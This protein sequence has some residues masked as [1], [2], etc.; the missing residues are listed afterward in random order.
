MVRRG[1]SL[2]PSFSGHGLLLLNSFRHRQLS[3]EFGAYLLVVSLPASL[4]L[5]IPRYQGLALS[6]G[7]YLYCGSAYGPGGIAARVAR[8]A[9]RE[10]ARR[11][12]IDHL[13][14]AGEVVLALA[15]PLASECALVTRLCSAGACFP[16]PGF[17]SSD[18][19]RC[20]AHLLRG[21]RSIVSTLVT[22]GTRIVLS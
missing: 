7:R 16:L 12:H 21:T 22:S 20:P 10:K 2:S 11:W 1:N 5:T 17:G 8:H 13:T 19:R 14:V 6:P 3:A 18:C 9:R 4:D 15:F